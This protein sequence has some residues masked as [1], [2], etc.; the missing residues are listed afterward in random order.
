ML[1]LLLPHTIWA[2][3]NLTPAYSPDFNERVMV[4]ISPLA[5]KSCLPVKSIGINKEAL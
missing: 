4:T 5:L 2:F 3:Q 1:K